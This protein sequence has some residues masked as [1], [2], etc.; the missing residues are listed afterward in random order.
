M[1][2]QHT[3]G[4]VLRGIG[5]I[6]RLREKLFGIRPSPFK[7]ALIEKV[8]SEENI[9]SFADLGGVWGVDGAYSFH[10][11]AGPGMSR[12][13]LVDNHFTD[14]VLRKGSS[15]PQLHL[16]EG[17]FRIES[18]VARIGHV[19]LILLF[20]VL[21]HQVNWQDIL[22]WCS[23]RAKVIVIHN[24]Q[25]PGEETLRLLDLGEQEY[26]RVVPHSK[27]GRYYEDLF[28][29]RE[30]RDTPGVWQWGICDRDLVGVLEKLDFQLTYSSDG[31]HWGDTG[32]QN[33]GFIF[34]RK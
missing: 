2:S 1:G 23:R 29:P 14:E 22:E 5:L 18:T 15:Y 12:G 32:F 3:H 9:T 10:L 34:Q 6:R 25:W 33:K 16:V 11:L 7:V 26:F 13:Y 31:E 4:I 27:E 28:T 21:L 19:D 8:L 30:Q 20:D 17:D 24:P